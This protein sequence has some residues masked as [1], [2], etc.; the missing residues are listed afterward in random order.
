MNIFEAASLMGTVAGSIAGAVI[1]HSWFGWL[2]RAIGLPIGALVGWFVPPF[3]VFGVFL[4]AI[5]FESGLKE[6]SNFLRRSGRH[7]P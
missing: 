5:C 7:A 3:I 2:G 4:I 6:A 1:G